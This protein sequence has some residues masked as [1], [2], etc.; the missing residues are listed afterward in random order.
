VTGQRWHAYCRAI[1][2]LHPAGV[3]PFVV[4]PAPDRR[5]GEWPWDHRHPVHVIT[6]W[7]PD[8]RQ[9]SEGANRASQRTLE[10]DL[11]AQGRDLCRA[12]GRDPTSPHREE[13]V[14]VVG[15]TDARAAAIGREHGQAAIFSWSWSPTA[16]AVVSCTGTR[17]HRSGW[18]LRPLA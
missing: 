12:V 9:L 17:T 10:A 6:A 13:S 14:A 18:V 5:A 11:V 4:W 15:L 7:N 3:D 8:S 16:W 2:E 1:V